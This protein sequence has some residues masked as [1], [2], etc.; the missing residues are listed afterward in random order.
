MHMHRALRLAGRARG[1]EPE[2][3]VVACGRRGVIL[4]L[5]GADD[6]VKQPVAVRVGAGDDDVL[7]IGAILDQLLEFRE[8]R[9]R[10]HQAFRPAVGQ[11]EAVVVLGE[12]RIDRHGDDAG[13]QAAEKR[14]RPVHGVEQRQQHALFAV[15]AQAAQRRAETRHPVGELP[16]GQRVPAVDIG[17]L[18]RAAGSE[19]AL[20]DIG[21]EIVIAWDHAHGLGRACLPHALRRLSLLFLPGRCVLCAPAAGCKANYI[22]EPPYGR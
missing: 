18:F 14:G 15:D 10:H 5:V 1:V 7:E 2:R 13:F 6:V 21:G 3:H 17:R 20:Q 12:Q 11:H 8:Q 16:I 4:R 22:S 9:L 19:I